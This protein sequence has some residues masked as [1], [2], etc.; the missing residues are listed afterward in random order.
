[1]GTNDNLDV[2]ECFGEH[3]VEYW[4]RRDNRLV[5]ATADEVARIHA[6]ERERSMLARLERLKDE[7]R[8][9]RTVM[10]R[11]RIVIRRFLLHV[12][13]AHDRSLVGADADAPAMDQRAHVE[14]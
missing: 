3:D 7:E 1:M 10:F 8:R 9:R 5:P 11:L 2:E 4:V 13:G 12:P 6:W 14:V